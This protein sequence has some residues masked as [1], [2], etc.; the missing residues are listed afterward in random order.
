MP[1]NPA[2]WLVVSATAAGASLVACAAVLGLDSGSALEGADGSVPQLDAT[3]RLDGAVAP[4]DAGGGAPDAF[5]AG[6]AAPGR[7]CGQTCVGQDRPEFGC[8]DPAC[9]AC[10]FP[11]AQAS[12]AAGKCA[13]GACAP[14]YGDCNGNAAD[15]CETLLNTGSQCGTCNKP[16]NVGFV[17]DSKTLTCV[18]A[19]TCTTP[20]TL[21]DG[22]TCTNTNDDATN[23]GGCGISCF[24][25]PGIV[26]AS[27]T[28]GVC[29][30][31]CDSTHLNCNAAPDGCETTI[32]ENNCGTCGKVCGP[33][34]VNTIYGCNV[35]GASSQ[36]VVSCQ[37]GYQNCDGNPPLTGCPC[38][39]SY[40]CNGA[41]CGS[42]GSDASTDSGQVGNCLG[43][44]RQPPGTSCMAGSGSNMC[45]GT[46]QGGT[47]FRPA[48]EA[49]TPGTC[50]ATTGQACRTGTSDCCNAPCGAGPVCL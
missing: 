8:A 17:C 15:G 32:N 39:T 19:L 25:G 30:Y 26:S 47:T 27:C 6:C 34:P 48:P 24:G 14:S 13:L 18:S 42:G 49:P 36:C 21:C 40:A 28:G 41:S 45:C 37:V 10:T 16:C 20:K 1:Q 22:G 11:N 2:L 44:G 12:C 5:G 29:G 33:P 7:L 31:V 23:C 38:S 35:N 46:C 4:S 9:K 50:C 43:P 3:G